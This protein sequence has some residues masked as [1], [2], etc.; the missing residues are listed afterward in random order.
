MRSF[1]CAG[2][3]DQASPGLEPPAAR[4]FRWTPAVHTHCI[5]PKICKAI[6]ASTQSEE[7]C[8]WVQRGQ[9]GVS[10]VTCWWVKSDQWLQD[11]CNCL[12][13]RKSPLP[14]LAGAVRRH[15]GARRASGCLVS[16]SVR[17][18]HPKGKTPAGTSG[19]PLRCPPPARWKRRGQGLPPSCCR[20]AAIVRLPEQITDPCAFSLQNA[21]ASTRLRLIFKGSRAGHSL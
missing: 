10:S 16:C 17:V 19:R 12:Q 5:A 9:Q 21:Y 15:S 6:I 14:T 3:Q 18:G 2:W 4:L 7:H 13:E 8:D 20:T 1:G 11:S